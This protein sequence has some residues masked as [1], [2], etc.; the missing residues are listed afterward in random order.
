MEFIHRSEVIKQM[1]NGEPFDIVFI[2]MDRK[3]GTG[4]D[5]IRLI[6]WEKMTNEPAP[7]KATPGARKLSNH[8]RNNNRTATLINPQAK[9]HHPITVHA[10]LIQF[11]NNKRVFNG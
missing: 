2:T 4:G 8:F 7:Q 1:D 6:G 10:D 3:R 11:F 5:I 9:H